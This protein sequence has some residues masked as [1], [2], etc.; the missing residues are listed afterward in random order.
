MPEGLWGENRPALV[1]KNKHQPL[2]RA[3]KSK[4]PAWAGEG[5]FC[6]TGMPM[7]GARD[8]N[9][10]GTACAEGFSSH[11]G[12]RRQLQEA[13]RALDYAFTLAN[14]A[15][16]APRLVSTPSPFL[17]G[18]ARRC[19]GHKARGFAE[20]EGIHTGAFA[21]WCSMLK[22]KS[23]VST[24]FTTRARVRPA[25]ATHTLTHK[26]TGQATGRAPQNAG[27][28][29]HY[30]GRTYAKR[31]RRCCSGW[32]IHGKTGNCSWFYNAPP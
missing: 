29:G 30:R 24:N 11:H 16:G 22:I 7:A 32:R 26:H 27:A 13:V 2:G 6:K 5:P 21:P 3:C 4:P 17:G 15:V 31:P 14:F 25:S 20:F 23:L 28:Y 18:L 9:R 19:L 10:T 12:F 8:R 1:W